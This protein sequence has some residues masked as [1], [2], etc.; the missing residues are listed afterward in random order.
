M[1]RG[2]TSL[3]IPT[4][5]ALLLACGCGASGNSDP[6]ADERPG[7]GGSSSSGGSGGSGTGG[8]SIG[9]A[10]GT[11]ASGG[12]TS[13]CT[14]GEERPCYT[15]PA[16]AAGVGICAQGVEICE[17]NGEFTTFGACEGSILPEEEVCAN[18]LDD[19]CDGQVDEDCPEDC[20]ETVSINISGD[21]VSVE[22]PPHAPY[23]YSC[24]VNFIGDT[25]HGCVAS[26]PDAP[27]VFFKEGVVCDAGYLQGTLTCSCKQSA[28]LDASNC[29]INK[30]NKHYKSTASEC[31]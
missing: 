9:S 31:P 7:N 27:K 13:A 14:P 24:A 6:V 23:P 17:L 11:G 2:M 22:C 15:G 29:S 28:G 5:F 12:G 18:G 25:P 26:T 19:D 20:L 4:L 1:A 16:S 30:A 3:R 21:C 10:S 8:A